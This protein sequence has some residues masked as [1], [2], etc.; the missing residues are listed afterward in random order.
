MKTNIYPPDTTLRC[1]TCGRTVRVNLQLCMQNGSALP[2]CHGQPMRI[3]ETSADVSAALDA[4]MYPISQLI[5]SALTA[6][7][8]RDGV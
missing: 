4:T 1:S 3:A 5:V 7:A 2:T 8:P 6:A